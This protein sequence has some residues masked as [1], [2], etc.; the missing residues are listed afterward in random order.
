M[1]CLFRVPTF[2]LICD[3]SGVLIAAET[4]EQFDDAISTLSLP[5]GEE[6]PVID[7]S[8]EGWVFHVDYMVMS[9]MTIKKRWTKKEIIALYNN[10][11]A[12]KRSG[13]EYSTKSLSAKRIDR[14]I[15]EVA[16]L[17]RASTSGTVEGDK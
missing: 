8:A 1:K 13:V 7:G 9:P 12:A 17:V 15:A 2:P 6:L 4:P 3:V 10:S 5:A 14:I 11:D 16:A